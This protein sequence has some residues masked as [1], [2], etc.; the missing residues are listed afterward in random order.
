[1]TSIKAFRKNGRNVLGIK[2]FKDCNKTIVF[3]LRCVTSKF[4]EY[5][6][7]ACLRYYLNSGEFRVS[8]PNPNEVHQF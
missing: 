4:S 3:G 5:S 6:G 1:M 8:S 7:D 2:L